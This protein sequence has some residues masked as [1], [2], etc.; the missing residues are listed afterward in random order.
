MSLPCEV[1][2]HRVLE[3]RHGEES[4]S[5]YEVVVGLTSEVVSHDSFGVAFP[6]ARAPACSSFWARTPHHFTPV[7]ARYSDEGI[8]ATTQT[9]HSLDVRESPPTGRPLTSQGF[10]CT[11]S[12]RAFDRRETEEAGTC[13][14]PSRLRSFFLL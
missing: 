7:G 9:G 12:F 3:Q 2:E 14:T 1:F 8:T 4:L 13:V 11:L 5:K 6:E 10:G